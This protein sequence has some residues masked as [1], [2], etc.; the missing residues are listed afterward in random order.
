MEQSFHCWVKH[1]TCNNPFSFHHVQQHLILILI[2]HSV[3]IHGVKSKAISTWPHY[4]ATGQLPD[5]AGAQ[6][7]GSTDNRNQHKV[8]T[9]F[10]RKLLHDHISVAQE[11]QVAGAALPLA[12]QHLCE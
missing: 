2:N 12:P 11:E 7:S 9:R 1:M 3:G 10:M 8:C 5:E 6:S 4:P